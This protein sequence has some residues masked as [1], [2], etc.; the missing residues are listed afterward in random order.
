MC[1]SRP[2]GIERDAGKRRQSHGASE[3]A[4][5]Q[6]PAAR[7]NLLAAE[8]RLLFYVTVFIT[9]CYWIFIDLIQQSICICII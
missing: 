7:S 1:G 5:L 3:D 4:A 9:D 2:R 8:Q 6:I